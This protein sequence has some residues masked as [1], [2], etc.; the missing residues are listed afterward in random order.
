MKISFNWLRELVELRPGVTADSVADR[1]TLA[2]LEVES[3]ERRGRE[4]SGVVVAEVRGARPHPS[5]EKLSIVRVVAGGPE[6]EVV[7]GAA[8]VPAPG[9]KVVWAPPGATLP[10]GHKLERREI[11]GVAS[12]GMLCSEVELGLAEASDGILILSP[13]AAAGADFA[14]YAGLLDEVL[15]VNVTPNRPDALSHAGIA[16]EVAAL[17]DTR[18]ALP[19]PDDVPLVAL[20]QGR[21]VDVEIRDPDACPRYLAR[22]VT[23]LAVRPSPLA[24]RV[25]LAACGVR[26][27]SNLVDV[28]NYVMLET[29]HPLHAFDADRLRGDIQVRRAGRGERMTTLDG[30]DRALQEGDIVIADGRG[31]IALAGVMGGAESEVSA[32]TTA[33]L[34]EAATFDP[35]AVR[36]T[37]KRL[38]LRSEASHRFERGVDAAGV[39]HASRRAAAMLARLG[40]GALAGEGVDRYPRAAE[41]RR[42]TLTRAG[43]ARLAGFPIPLTQAAEKL[44]AIG[45]ASEPDAAAPDERLVAAAPTFRP[46]VTI[47]EDLVEEVMRLVGYD[48]V[49]ARLP[50]SSGAPA[51]SPEGLADRARDLLAALGLSEIVSWG[52]VPRAWL[53]VL[54]EVGGDA[55]LANGLAVKNPISA[56]YELLRTS[57]LPLLVDAAKRNLARGVADVA[58]YEV[59]PVVRRAADAKEAPAEPV[60]A[61]AIL[62]GRRPDWLKPGDAYDFYDAK[63]VAEEL[64]RGLGVAGATFVPLAGRG[65]L[66]PG[67]GAEIR[68]GGADGRVAGQVGEIHPR[69]TAALGLDARALYL[70]IALDAV[71]SE[72]RPVRSVAPPRFPAVTRDISFWIDAATSADAQRAILTSTAEPLLRALAVLED[73]RDPRYA[74]AGKKGMLWTL[75]YRADDRTLTDAEVDAAHARVVAALKTSP[76]VAIR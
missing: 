51:P 17:F 23:G 27:I 59:G 57:L 29:G 34:L 61:A 68:I 62:V 45:I 50:R 36:R 5:A 2:G 19:A 32:G 1:L 39:L 53:A 4:T 25:R 65:L 55:G 13:D 76:S 31:A 49:P 28:T 66:H 60:H 70:E 3:I 73:Y 20:P 75:T 15:E 8:N 42:V 72:R 44:A 69:L 67:V 40:G 58:L 11:R 71:G 16:R 41:P 30:A 47:E 24:L 46:D 48:R 9:G 63:L 10:G 52:F 33:V 35:R 64:L 12:P 7:C 37:S 6:E 26:A 56:D 38:G 21:G 22:M 14:R 18:W 54:G 43:L 74:P